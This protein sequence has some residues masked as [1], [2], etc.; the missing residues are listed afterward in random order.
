MDI[1]DVLSGLIE[2]VRKEGALPK[3]LQRAP[4][5][6]M[7][8]IGEKDVQV[9]VNQ[10]F[11]RIPFKTLPSGNFG[12]LS[13]NGGTFGTG[14][15]IELSHMTCGYFYY[16][17]VHALNLEVME[18]AK[19]N[20]SVVDVFAELLSDSNDMMQQHQ[21]VL[22]HTSGNGVLTN[23]SSAYGSA[24]YTFASAT[25]FLGV[26]RLIE[27]MTVDVWDSS[28]ATDKGERRIIKIDHSAK[29][30]TLDSAP[31]SSPTAG[32]RL[33]I[34]ALDVYG[35]STPT[36]FA[37]SYPTA[38][39]S[40][41]TGDS[42]IHGLDYYLNTTSSNYVLG[43]QKSTIPQLNPRHIAAGS[44]ALTYLHPIRLIHKM[45][46]NRGSK[47]EGLVALVPLAQVEQLIQI[48][49]AL[50]TVQNIGDSFG[51]I[52]NLSPDN[53]DLAGDV[54]FGSIRG[55][56]DL[57]QSENGVQVIDPS[58]WGKVEPKK[59][60]FY[61]VGGDYIRATRNSSGQLTAGAEFILY[62]A[63]DHFCTDVGKQGVVDGLTV[64]TGSF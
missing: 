57:R 58:L 7:S 40:G 60:D 54:P 61:K 64:P 1:T 46:R 44:V 22:L 47:G 24:V 31:S 43:V 16:S 28:L 25:D 52:K 37:S 27:G 53:P 41:I 14:N 33:A 9:D 35:P 19:G 55:K 36:T 5:L 4:D 48:N 3:M 38:G 11:Y 2:K 49:M 20:G 59:V 13:A 10:K 29:T 39:A 6:V 15:G 30:V 32:D 21:E 23:A 8:L 45:L 42:F 62:G 18:T 34:R 63:K 17:Q 56:V 26:N 50:Q 51:K 12:K